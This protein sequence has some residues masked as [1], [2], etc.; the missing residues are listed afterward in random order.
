[1]APKK[2]TWKD[3]DIGKALV[4]PVMQAGG[5]INPVLNSVRGVITTINKAPGPDLPVPPKNPIKMA[6]GGTLKKG[7]PPK[8]RGR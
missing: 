7:K 2:Y 1:M 8:R 5:R 6:K 3:N 4:E